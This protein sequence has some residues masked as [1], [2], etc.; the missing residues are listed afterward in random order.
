MSD[1]RNQEDSVMQA[2]EYATGRIL[3]F[4]ILRMCKSPVK[5]QAAV[6]DHFFNISLLYS[7]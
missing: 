5:T 4:K 1:E 6:A 3:E 7:V 2:R